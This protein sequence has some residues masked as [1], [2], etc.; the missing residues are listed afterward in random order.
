MLFNTKFSGIMSRTTNCRRTA[1]AHV[2]VSMQGIILKQ[3]EKK[4]LVA[5]TGKYHNS[6]ST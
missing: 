6:L 5:E 1:V 2:K 4:R 3:E